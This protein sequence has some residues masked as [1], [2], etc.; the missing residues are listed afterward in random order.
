MICPK[1]SK[2]I[3]SSTTFCTFCGEKLQK[4]KFCPKCGKEYT[5]QMVF[6]SQCGTR[7]S[8]DTPQIQSIH[9][10]CPGCG[11]KLEAEKNLCGATVECPSC[12]RQITVPVSPQ[13]TSTANCIINKQ[14]PTP[15]PSQDKPIQT[16]LSEAI[17]V[18]AWL[19]TLGGIFIGAIAC[20]FLPF[21]IVAIV[22]AVKAKNK[23][24]AG[25]ISE[26]LVASR[27]AK[28]WLWVTASA[29]LIFSLILGI[30][31]ISMFFE[32]F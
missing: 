28:I 23:I 3:P 19:I 6:C 14:V 21:C 5:S 12:K 17:G 16:H 20:L 29:A 22:Y 15:M 7:L 18:A 13:K 24:A 2:E 11:Q 30:Y 27:K 31:G 8:E 10:F 1:C 4:R 9:F 26:A 32:I 25:D